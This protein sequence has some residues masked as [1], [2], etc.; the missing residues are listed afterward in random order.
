M[1]RETPAVYL[2]DGYPSTWVWRARRI[3]SLLTGHSFF[4]WLI[5]G[6]AGPCARVFPGRWGRC[7]GSLATLNRVPCAVANRWSKTRPKLSCAWSARGNS[8]AQD[9]CQHWSQKSRAT[10]TTA[11]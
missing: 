2:K 11:R 9:S 8:G 5:K 1:V 10:V 3:Q 6:R 4:P 7:P